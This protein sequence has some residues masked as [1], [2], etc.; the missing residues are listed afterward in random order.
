M[1]KTSKQACLGCSVPIESHAPWLH[2]VP[3]ILTS[4]SN[5][6]AVNFCNNTTLQSQVPPSC[7]C[8]LLCRMKT[9]SCLAHWAKLCYRSSTV[10]L[11]PGHLAHFSMATKWQMSPCGGPGAAVW[12]MQNHGPVPPRGWW[13]GRDQCRWRCG[14]SSALRPSPASGS[15]RGTAGPGESGRLTHF[16]TDPPQTESTTGRV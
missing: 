2:S 10:L 8:P 15:P 16:G 1:Q 11:L 6:P 7:P 3:R 12:M 5:V 4:V 13:T 14:G 9:S